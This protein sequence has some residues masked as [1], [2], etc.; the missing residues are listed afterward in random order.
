MGYR[1]CVFDRQEY[2]ENGS[3]IDDCTSEMCEFN[4]DAEDLAYELAYTRYALANAEVEVERLKKRNLDVA[5][6]WA[7]ARSRADDRLSDWAHEKKLRQQR[8]AELA[9]V[10]KDAEYMFREID[11]MHEW[12]H[13]D[14]EDEMREK[15][16][17]E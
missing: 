5:H 8:E 12:R 17:E 13:H 6:D 7:I 2:L 1:P 4:D 11:R 3:D 16:G 15:Y 14:E 9:E 10:R